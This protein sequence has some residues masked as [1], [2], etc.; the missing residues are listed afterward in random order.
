MFHSGCLEMCFWDSRG[1]PAPKFRVWLN[2]ICSSYCKEH[3]AFGNIV[4]ME[5]MA[6]IICSSCQHGF[7][8]FH[9]ARQKVVLSNGTYSWSR[10]DWTLLIMKYEHSGSSNQVLCSVRKV[11]LNGSGQCPVSKLCDRTWNYLSKKTLMWG[12]ST[13]ICHTHGFNL[14]RLLHSQDWNQTR[15]IQE[16]LV[17]VHLRTLKVVYKLWGVLTSP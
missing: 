10:R 5:I 8:D 11:C 2:L 16:C 3:A 15:P 1:K 12:S 9:I 13:L 7:R 17:T 6:L 4:V 14:L